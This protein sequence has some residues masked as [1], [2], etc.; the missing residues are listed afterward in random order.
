[1]LALFGEHWKQKN[2]IE[3]CLQYGLKHTQTEMYKGF[4]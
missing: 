1:M 2:W 4:S 3:Y